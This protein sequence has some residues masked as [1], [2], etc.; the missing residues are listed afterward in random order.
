MGCRVR[1][2]CLLMITGCL[3]PDEVVATYLD[4]DGD[5]ALDASARGG[6]DCDDGDATIG[7][8]A[9]ELCNGIDDDCDGRIDEQATDAPVW[10]EDLDGDGFAGDA[11]TLASCTAPDG[12]W[13]DA[14]TDCDDR[15]AS[16]FPGAIDRCD[17]GI[18]NDCDGAIDEDGAVVTVYDDVDGDGHGDPRSAP[19][20]L[21]HVPAGTASL[22]DDCDD[23]DASVFPG[24]A[25]PPY[26]GVDSACDGDVGEFDADGDGYETDP[27]LVTAPGW[28]ASTAV[29]CDDD[30]PA[31]NPQ[32]TEV[33]YDAVDQDCD[34]SDLIDCD[35]DG[36]DSAEHGGTDCDDTDAATFPGA[37]DPPRDGVDSD[38]DPTWDDDVDRDGH[39][40][41]AAGGDDCDDDDPE[42]WSACET[43]IDADGDGAWTA[44]DSYLTREEDCD[45]TDPAV[46]PGAPE[47]FG[48][49]IDED[50]SGADLGE[51]PSE[52]TWVSPEGTD[53]PGCGALAAPCATVAGTDGS[54]PVFLTEGVHAPFVATVSVYGGFSSVSGVHDP[55]TYP[56]IVQTTGGPAIQL[57][58]VVAELGTLSVRATDAVLDVELVDLTGGQLTVFDLSLS[59][60]HTTR[61][62]LGLRADVQD[63]E[64]DRLDLRGCAST[65]DSTGLD[66]TVDDASLNDLDLQ[67]AGSGFAAVATGIL[68]RGSGELAIR[69]STVMIEG[70]WPG[71]ALT[72]A[73]NAVLLD[74]TLTVAP[75]ERGFGPQPWAVGGRVGTL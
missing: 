57:D 73:G 64:V 8:H 17:D 24:A 45:D 37:V 38:C 7:P 61:T 72:L 49:G 51:D 34:G 52:G 74:S 18:D 46:S 56:S 40:A 4:A 1:W 36:F 13:S 30:D 19:R 28:Q 35:G 50:C 20:S 3:V 15:D 47:R 66:L 10:F 5:G 32:A 42:L 9:A 60:E 70:H 39:L 6:T 33:C 41:S 11:S 43:C 58:S 55:A 71:R 16:S 69:D 75:I 29:D 68:Q 62:C 21:C 44:C 23:R 48:N 67:L 63:L 2:L 59:T 25:D 31:L 14:P 26:D 12:A 27:A 22:A 54:G 53:T 65:L